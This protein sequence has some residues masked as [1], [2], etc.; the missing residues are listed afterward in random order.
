[1][2]IQFNPEIN[3]KY[4]QTQVSNKFHYSQ[5]KYQHKDTCSFGNSN[6]TPIYD[7]K[8]NLLQSIEF[9][10]PITISNALA[11]IANSND[12]I[13]ADNL[14]KRMHTIETLNELSQILQTKEI[15][16]TKVKSL[17][18]IGAFAL[19]FET[20]NGQILKITD[21]EHFP[22]GRKPAK[23]DLPIIQSGK[24]SKFPPYHYYLEEKV[25]QNDL[26][27]EELRTIVKEIKSL[28]YRMKDYLIHYDTE[29][30]EIIKKDQFGRAKNGK[31]YLIDPG[32]AIETDK[33]YNSSKKYNLKNLL[34]RLLK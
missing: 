31:I 16:K 33:V 22:N 4:N 25:T 28:G 23:F 11:T 21:T 24:L 29:G 34:K 17:I 19:A 2:N 13:L 8:Y 26:T 10:K 7:K 12:S 3:K 1:M 14:I 27:Q 15:G 30:Y 32:C 6:I 18:G 20:E 9:K 5:I